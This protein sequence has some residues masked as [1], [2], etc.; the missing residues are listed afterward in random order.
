MAPADT[1]VT[2][3]MSSTSNKIGTSVGRALLRTV[4]ASA[5]ASHLA[6]YALEANSIAAGLSW[7][8][9]CRRFWGDGAPSCRAARRATWASTP[10]D[11]VG[12]RVCEQPC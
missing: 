12:G 1:G 4:A 11:P 5:T 2:S 9:D 10:R 6:A 3:A 8:R 7:V